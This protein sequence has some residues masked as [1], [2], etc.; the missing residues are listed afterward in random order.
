MKIRKDKEPKFAHFTCITFAQYCIFRSK[1]GRGLLTL[2]PNVVIL[3]VLARDTQRFPLKDRAT[4]DQRKEGRGGGMGEA[5]RLINQIRETEVVV[6]QD[7]N[8]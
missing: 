7:L 4:V 1:F 5:A 2:L 6:V 8:L 3:L